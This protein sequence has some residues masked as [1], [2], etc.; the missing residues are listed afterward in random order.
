V[1]STLLQKPSYLSLFLAKVL[2]DEYIYYRDCFR[3]QLQ[4]E[5]SFSFYL[6]DSLFLGCDHLGID[7]RRLST[8]IVSFINPDHAID[9]YY[10]RCII[11]ILHPDRQLEV[12]SD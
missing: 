1:T 2:L 9:G 5:R 12:Q 10:F 4:E 6:P 11:D 8:D 3:S 7:K